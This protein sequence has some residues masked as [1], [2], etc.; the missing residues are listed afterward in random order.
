MKQTFLIFAIVLLPIFGVAQTKNFIDQPYL[1]TQASV[2]TLVTPDRIFLTI[3]LNESDNKNKVST[4]ELEQSMKKIF[5]S[6]GIDIEKDL[7]LLDINSNF[8][9]YFLSDQKVLK[10]KIYSLKVSDAVTAGKVISGLERATISNVSVEKVEYSQSEKLSLILKSKAISKAKI[11][12]E[13]LVVPLGQK[14][15]SAIYISDMNSISNHLQGK[16]AGIQIRGQS[17][18]YGSRANNEPLA[19]EFNKIEFSASVLVRFKIE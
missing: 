15:G 16:A 11:N 9:K 19:I 18:I 2:D 3:I 6:L 10:T 7:T 1:E 8:K 14:I 17:S 13:S 12:A 4:E 5:E